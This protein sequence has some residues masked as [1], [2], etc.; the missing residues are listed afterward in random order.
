MVQVGELRAHFIN[1]VKG[2]GTGGLNVWR[3]SSVQDTLYVRESVSLDLR[4]KK[5]SVVK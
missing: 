3:C 4:R 2:S 5:Q 1:K